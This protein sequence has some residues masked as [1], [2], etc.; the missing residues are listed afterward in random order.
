MEN[1]SKALL[2]AGGVLIALIIMSLLVVTFT[3]IGDYQKSQSTS[4]KESELAKFN[5]DFERYTE[6]EIKGIDIVSLINKIH[7]YNTKKESILSGDSAT[8][9]TAIDYNIKMKL[10]VSGLDAFNKKYAYSDEGSSEQLFNST[11]YTFTYDG[12]NVNGNKIRDAFNDFVAGEEKATIPVLKKVSDVYDKSKR[13]EQN[14][15]NIK[16]KLC[17]IDFDTYENWNGSS[18]PTYDTIKKYRQY[19][20]FKSDK[21][22]ASDTPKYKNGQ[23]CELSFKY[24]E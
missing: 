13:K 16:E 8:D 24:K 14:I 21:F 17:K 1:A 23:I 9:S 4:S 5:R 6:G 3:K 7:D 10:T 15:K 12:T 11:L 2:I 18:T 22:I 20:E 19:S